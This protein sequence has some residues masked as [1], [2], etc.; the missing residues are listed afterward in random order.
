[1]PRVNLSLSNELF[2]ALQADSLS[3][4]CT[5]NVMILSILEQ[6][7]LQDP[8]DYEAAMHQLESEANQLPLNSEFT[9]SCLNSFSNIPVALSQKAILKPS[10]IRAR[11]GKMFNA[12]VRAGLLPGI[13]R[14]TDDQGALKFSAR[15]AVYKR[16]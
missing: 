16:I 10:T 11:L 3:H 1:M 8:F 4:D 6:L 7:Y 13:V 15:S 9:L 12:R 5:V 14:S 2:S